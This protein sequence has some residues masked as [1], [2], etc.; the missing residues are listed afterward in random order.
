[1]IL[2]AGEGGYGEYRI[3][4]VVHAPGG[5]VMC[6]EARSRSHDDWGKID[7]LILR[8]DGVRCVIAGG[9]TDT[10]NNPTLIV[11]G[12]HV[13][14]IYHVNYA[15]AFHRVSRDGGRTWSEPNEITS[16][17]REFPYEWNVCATGPG[18]GIR[19]TGGRLAVPVWLAH[20]NVHVGS[21]YR[22]DHFPSVAGIL[23]SD[24][25]GVSWHAGALVPGLPDGNETTVAELPDGRLL[26]NI[27][28]RGEVRRRARAISG[29]GGESVADARYEDGLPDPACFGSSV[30]A[31]EDVY[32]VNCADERARVN[33]TVKRMEGENWTPVARVDELGGYADIAFDGSSLCVFYESGVNG[34]I[35]EIRLVRV[36]LNA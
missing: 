24:D 25:R 6:C 3:P 16:A 7:V 15:R 28:H 10:V 19:M 2:R 8:E 22:V 29:D 1:M 23:Y 31:G 36:P 18:H 30:R 21:E 26:L 20:G 34:R 11:D 27:R 5:L 35:E 4:G 17:Y 9:E 13:H 14:L 12:E 33:L 32:F